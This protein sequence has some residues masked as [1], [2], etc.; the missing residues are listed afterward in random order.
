MLRRARKMEISV[1]AEYDILTGKLHV[2][3]SEGAEWNI[4]TPNPD[5]FLSS[6]IATSL[7]LEF[8]RNVRLI[9]KKKHKFKLA[10]KEL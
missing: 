10:Y 1:I 3:N 7:A 9:R 4:T 6:I 2:V 5:I 8:K